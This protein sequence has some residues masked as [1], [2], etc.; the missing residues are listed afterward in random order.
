MI[1]LGF[2]YVWVVFYKLRDK[3]P[4]IVANGIGANCRSLYRRFKLFGIGRS[5]SKS[6]A[7]VG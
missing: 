6:E 4:P 1:G 2:Y 3:H 5:I 7:I